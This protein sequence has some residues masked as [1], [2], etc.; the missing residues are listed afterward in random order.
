MTGA[1]PETGNT[2]FAIRRGKLQIR[3]AWA[4]GVLLMLLQLLTNAGIWLNHQLVTRQ[5]F[6]DVSKRL[7]DHETRLRS[8]EHKP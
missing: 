2:D 4:F 8:L 1:L 3:L 7:E 6:D 5:E